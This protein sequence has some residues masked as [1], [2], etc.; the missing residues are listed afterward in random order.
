MAANGVEEKILILIS[1]TPFCHHAGFWLSGPPTASGFRPSGF[2]A[3]LWVFLCL[4]TA[5]H[6]VS[7]SFN[8]VLPM[9]AKRPRPN[10]PPFV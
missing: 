9:G 5:V 1:F 2:P 8:Y 4:Q 10:P 6:M 7:S 3:G